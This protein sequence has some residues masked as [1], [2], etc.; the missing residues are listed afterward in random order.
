MALQETG[1]SIWLVDGDIVDFKY[2]ENKHN[3]LP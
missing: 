1:P 3:S 2:K